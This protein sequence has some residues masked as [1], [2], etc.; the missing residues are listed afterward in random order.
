MD[1]EHAIVIFDGKCNL[2]SGS[3]K[4]IIDRDKRR[5]FKFLS[6]QSKQA[7]HLLAERN[8][9]ISADSVILIENEEIYIR[10]RAALKISARLTWPWRIASWL[11]ILPAFLLDPFYKLIAK[12]RYRIWGKTEKCMLPSPDIKDRFLS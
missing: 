5:Y 10:S 12:C 8:V 1:N 6:L 2:C 11:K 9:R 7:Q 3:V 4:F